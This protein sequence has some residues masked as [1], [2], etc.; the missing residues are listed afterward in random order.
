M[1]ETSPPVTASSVWCRGLKSVFGAFWGL[2]QKALRRGTRVFRAEGYCAA[3]A[4]TGM[5]ADEST[6][7]FCLMPG[8][9]P[10]CLRHSRGKKS[11]AG[12]KDGRHFAAG[13]ETGIFP[14]K[15]LSSRLC[16]RGKRNSL[17]A[18]STPRL[19][20]SKNPPAGR[21]R[22]FAPDRSA[23]FMGHSVYALSGGD[24]PAD[25]GMLSV[26]WQRPPKAGGRKAQDCGRE[27]ACN[28]APK[29][30]PVA[31]G[32]ERVIHSPRP[33][34]GGKKRFWCL[35]GLRPKGTAARHPCVFV[36]KV[37][38]P[39]TRTQVCLPNRK[40]RRLAKTQSNTL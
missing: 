24:R 17:S 8:S 39:H 4:H 35:L 11:L 34:D 27:R 6:A 19:S 22:T 33:P 14:A 7:P 25:A 16:S 9:Q 12:Q 21:P 37:I 20:L 26:N 1:R 13:R 23:I 10:E 40:R 15:T 28:L 2:G 31:P 30:Q 32:G 18:I 5:S 38:A 36:R 29:A 3:Y